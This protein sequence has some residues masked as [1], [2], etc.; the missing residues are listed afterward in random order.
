[1][2]VPCINMT[3]SSL[4]VFQN[5]GSDLEDSR[6][7]SECSFGLGSALHLNVTVADHLGSVHRWIVHYCNV[8]ILRLRDICV[9]S[10]ALVPLSCEFIFTG[11]TLGSS[12]YLYGMWVGGNFSQVTVL[13]L[14]G[15]RG[16]GAYSAFRPRRWRD[17]CYK[18]LYASIQ[19]DRIFHR[20]HWHIW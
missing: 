19:L 8:A 9:V 13:I 6:R 18:M 1:M 7:T 15:R 11:S 17:I 14:E 3:I 10:P 16:F 12:L 20:G 4:F 2:L 5:G